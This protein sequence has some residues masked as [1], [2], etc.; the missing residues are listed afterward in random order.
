HCGTDTSDPTTE[1]ES[2]LGVL[3]DAL[4]HVDRDSHVT[5]VRVTGN[6]MQGHPQLVGVDDRQ[7]VPERRVT[8]RCE[9]VPG[10]ELSRRGGEHAAVERMPANSVL[11]GQ[12]PGIARQDLAD[13]LEGSHWGCRHDSRD[14]ER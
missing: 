4:S 2:D 7:V 9:V 1:S 5:A 3:L 13:R 6:R 10:G 12:V 11:E 8:A 14:A